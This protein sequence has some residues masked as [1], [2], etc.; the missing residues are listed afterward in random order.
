MREDLANIE[1]AMT[2][3]TSRLIVVDIEAVLH[4]VSI[5]YAM[6]YVRIIMIV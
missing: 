3:F 2:R 5:H 4:A 6:Q 1:N